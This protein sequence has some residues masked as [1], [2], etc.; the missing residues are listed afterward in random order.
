MN[1]QVAKT[2]A[3]RIKIGIEYP[4]QP[5][6]ILLEE[7]SKHLE[8]KP[9]HW[10]QF[11]GQAC[12]ACAQPAQLA[13]PPRSLRHLLA[14]RLRNFSLRGGT[15]NFYVSSC[16]LRQH[17]FC[18]VYRKARRTTAG[19]LEMFWSISLTTTIGSTSCPPRLASCSS[20]AKSHSS[21]LVGTHTP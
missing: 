5:L 15:C 17:A 8:N 18:K 4:R 3:M 16:F 11:P 7:A 21:N 2:L 19:L 10:F 6:A 9:G 1:I 20:I 14:T 12:R 13:Q